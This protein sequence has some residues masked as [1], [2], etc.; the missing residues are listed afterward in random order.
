MTL[1]RLTSLGCAVLIVALGQASLPAHA[2]SLADAARLAREIRQR[3]G[4]PTKVYTDDDLSDTPL[5]QVSTNEDLPDTGGSTTSPESTDSWDSRYQSQLEAALERERRLLELLRTQEVRRP[6]PSPTPVPEASGIPLYY[7]YSVFVA[8]PYNPRPRHGTTVSKSM[9]RHRRRSRGPDSKPRIRTD[10]RPPS[11]ER[12][13]EPSS[14]RPAATNGY[15]QSSRPFPYVSRGLRV[16]S[17][18]RSG[19]GTR[20]GTRIR[21]RATPA[22][23]AR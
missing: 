17:P 7:A 14:R 5:T 8:S 12:R 15:E 18:H 22:A 9:G 3:L 13:V 2:Q 23:G 4:P 6:T 11:S 20:T 19:T 1:R 10:R 16:P 21:T